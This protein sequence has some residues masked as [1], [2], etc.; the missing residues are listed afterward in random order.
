MKVVLTGA[1]SFTGLWFAQALVAQGHAVVAPLRG[2]ADG[3]DALRQ[4]RIARLGA[5]GVRVVDAAPF[6]ASRFLALL[7]E[8][9][10]VLC[11]HGAEVRGHKDIGFD[12]IAAVAANTRGA[13]EVLARAAAAGCRALVVSGSVFEAGE[14]CGDAPLRAF[15]PYGLSKG[16]SWDVLRF[17]AGQAGIAAAKFVLPNPFGP[18]EAPRFGHHLV[19]Q[20]MQRRV[21]RVATPDYVRDNIHVDLLAIAYRRFVED[22]AGKGGSRRAAPSGYVETQGA[23]AQR[24]A[25]EVGGRLGLDA[26]LELAPQPHFIEPRVRINTDAVPVDAGEWSEAAAWDA[27]AEDLARRMARH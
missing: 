4:A 7:D 10:D 23:F 11:H 9:L 3:P 18:W 22:C 26:L 2:A 12:A 20:W 5:L 13:P 15:S 1:S 25:R 21:A 8:G 24:F 14:G 16:L 6:G 19:Q 17:W 27:T